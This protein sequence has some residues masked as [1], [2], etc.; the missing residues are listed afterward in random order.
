MI[1][2]EIIIPCVRGGGVFGPCFAMHFLVSSCFTLNAF[3]MY[4]EFKCSVAL[5]HAVGWSTVCDCD[6]S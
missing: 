4:C 1:R 6:I 2:C 3:L 5:P